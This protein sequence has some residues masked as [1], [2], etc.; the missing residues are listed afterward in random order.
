MRLIPRV[1]FPLLFLGRAMSDSWPHCMSEDVTR[2]WHA[3]AEKR[4]AHF[5]ELYD[6]GRWRRYYGESEFVAQM[7]DVVRLAE[8]WARLSGA[9]TQAPAE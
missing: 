9:P 5:I 4:R 6:S 7:R 8:T 2:K 3:L 1:I